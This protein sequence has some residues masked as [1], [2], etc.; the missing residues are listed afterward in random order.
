MEDDL[1]KK[2]NIDLSY[3]IPENWN[4]S[5]LISDSF[6]SSSSR[7]PEFQH[8]ILTAFSYQVQKFRNSRIQN[9]RI[10]ACLQP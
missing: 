6:E 1:N 3:Q 2:K 8:C 4:S 5:V 10:P 7:I 9:Y